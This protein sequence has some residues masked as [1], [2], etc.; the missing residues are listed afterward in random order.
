MKKQIEMQNN[1]EEKIDDIFKKNNKINKNIFVK[2]DYDNEI[3][4]NDNAE[5]EKSINELKELFAYV[6][7]QIQ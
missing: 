4:N 3:K 2:I 1:H 6:W 7:Q 5:R